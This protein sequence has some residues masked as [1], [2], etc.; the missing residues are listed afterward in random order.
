[1]KE[2]ENGIVLEIVVMRFNKGLTSQDHAISK[3]AI[4]LMG[5]WLDPF[6]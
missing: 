1:M 2:D 4:M 6:F 5:I 3:V